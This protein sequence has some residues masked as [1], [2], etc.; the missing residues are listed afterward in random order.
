MPYIDFG[1]WKKTSK[2]AN[3]KG[4][5]AK[6][7]NYL[8][9]EDQEAKQKGEDQEF[10]FNL[11]RDDITGAEVIRNIDNNKGKL[12]KSQSK[13][14]MVTV[15]PSQ[16]ELNHIN[17]D[18]DK[19]KTWLKSNYIPQLTKDFKREGLN[20]NDVNLYIKIEHNR[21]FRGDEAKLINKMN[22]FK[23]EGNEDFGDIWKNVKS[24]KIRGVK[25][26]QEDAHRYWNTN[27]DNV[28]A[29]DKK[30]GVN[31][32][33]HII[34]GRKVKNKNI[35]IST[36]NNHRNVTGGGC[37]KHGFNQNFSKVNTEKN[38][39]TYFQYQRNIE[40]SYEVK[41]HLQETK[42]IEERLTYLKNYQEQK[43]IYKQIPAQKKNKDEHEV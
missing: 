22:E 11:N 8:N 27:L 26:K 28:K 17:N 41:L 24:M 38:W 12:S 42:N 31:M 4:S 10:Y 25:V 23:K 7:V 21:Y 18:P 37:I 20:P 3:N 32:H 5:V 33:A 6:L 29:G 13:F 40:E 35:Y 16:K 34:L 36:R 15:N 9:K 43:Y 2:N 30:P 19:F 1:G 14:S 39:D